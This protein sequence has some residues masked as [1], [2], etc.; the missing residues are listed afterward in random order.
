M[1]FVNFLSI[2]MI[3]GRLDNSWSFQRV[4]PCVVLR[5]KMTWIHLYIFFTFYHVIIGSKSRDKGQVNREKVIVY[6][7]SPIC[8][9]SSC[10]PLKSTATLG[11]KRHARSARYLTLFETVMRI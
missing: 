7:T 6:L 1:R 11:Q 3:V 10:L 9:S 5:S 4:P 8:S 2:I